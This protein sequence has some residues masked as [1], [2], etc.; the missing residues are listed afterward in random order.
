MALRLATWGKE[1]PQ[2][3]IR[4][5]CCPC[6]IRICRGYFREPS[7]R[8]PSRLVKDEEEPTG[9]PVFGPRPGTWQCQSPG[10]G[11]GGLHQGRPCRNEWHCHG[12]RG[13]L[14]ARLW[15]QTALS[16]VPAST[17]WKPHKLIS[18]LQ[19]FLSSFIKCD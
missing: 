4:R 14:C 19:A 12:T 10:R 11:G 1:D 16:S 18:T 5:Q 17:S 13:R 8:N 9:S 15:R 3:I 6:H 2:R 7:A